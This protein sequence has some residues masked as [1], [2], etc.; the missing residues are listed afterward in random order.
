MNP[1]EMNPSGMSASLLSIVDIT[2][3]NAQQFLIVI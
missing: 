3:D 1:F 2:L